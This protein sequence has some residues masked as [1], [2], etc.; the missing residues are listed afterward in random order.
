[1]SIIGLNKKKGSFITFNGVPVVKM[2]LEYA[3]ETNDQ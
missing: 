1:M 3:N 2:M